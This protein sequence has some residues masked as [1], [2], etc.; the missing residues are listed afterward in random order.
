MEKVNNTEKKLQDTKKTIQGFLWLIGIVVVIIV[1]V[2]ACGGCGGSENTKPKYSDIPSQNTLD[3]ISCAFNREFK[4]AGNDIRKAELND[5]YLQKYK[6]YLNSLSNITGWKGSIF[7]IKEEKGDLENI[8]G[9][10][11]IYKDVSFVIEMEN[12]DNTAKI[13]LNCKHKFPEKDAV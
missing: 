13:Y 3:S 4:D 1:V 12:S 7:S 10:W 2:R 8:N 9:T 11:I 6:E 5:L